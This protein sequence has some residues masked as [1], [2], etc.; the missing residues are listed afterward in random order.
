[1][2]S[3][4]GAHSCPPPS[5]NVTDLEYWA[6]PDPA[7][8]TGETP[9]LPVA[10]TSHA[11]TILAQLRDDNHANENASSWSCDVLSSDVPSDQA[12]HGGG[13]ARVFGL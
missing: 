12:E 7:T 10:W 11:A 6:P 3:L 2:T 1:M 9:A 4:M 8:D 13:G 5:L